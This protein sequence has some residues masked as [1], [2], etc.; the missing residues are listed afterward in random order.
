LWEHCSFRCARAR[1]RY[2]QFNREAETA[3]RVATSA[4]IRGRGRPHHNKKSSRPTVPC[5]GPRMNPSVD[6]G[7]PPRP[8]RHLRMAERRSPDPSSSQVPVH[9]AL[10]QKSVTA[11]T[12]PAGR[13]SIW[14]LGK[15]SALSKWKTAKSWQA[16]CNQSN[17]W[18]T[19]GACQAGRQTWLAFCKTTISKAF[20]QRVGAR[21]SSDGSWKCLILLTPSTTYPPK[22]GLAF[23]NLSTRRKQSPERPHLIISKI[24][25]SRAQRNR[26]LRQCDQSTSAK[27]NSCRL[28]ESAPCDFLGSH[29]PS[30]PLRMPHPQSRPHLGW[31]FYCDQLGDDLLLRKGKPLRKKHHHARSTLHAP[32]SAAAD[33]PWPATSSQVKVRSASSAPRRPRLDDH[34]LITTP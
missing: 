6:V 4:G 11:I 8:F 30:M 13:L 14:M 18:F 32:P 25:F 33:F 1:I 19:N 10:V 22:H 34:A 3:A 12:N 2:Q 16:A 29:R 31:G 7:N 27:C 23:S 21:G 15:S 24:I 28:Q 9:S 20:T 5:D 17:A 26:A